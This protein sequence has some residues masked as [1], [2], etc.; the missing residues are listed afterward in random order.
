MF[1]KITHFS[2]F[3][4]MLLTFFDCYAPTTVS[5]ANA[6]TRVNRYQA[7]ISSEITL[8]RAPQQPV[9]VAQLLSSNLSVSRSVQQGFIVPPAYG[10]HHSFR[11]QYKEVREGARIAQKER[12]LALFQSELARLESEEGAT[13]ATHKGFPLVKA[14]KVAQIREE[15]AQL[16]DQISELSR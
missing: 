6:P 7:A 5:F 2:Y 14:R 12:S 16:I 13:I 1:R 8:P 9:Y 11:S 3:C 10:N 4:V 15:R